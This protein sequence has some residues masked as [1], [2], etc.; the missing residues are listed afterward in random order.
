MVKKLGMGSEE[1]LPD[2]D[3]EYAVM[4]VRFIFRVKTVK[5]VQTKLAIQMV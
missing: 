3:T 2:T 1:V 4:G 5:V